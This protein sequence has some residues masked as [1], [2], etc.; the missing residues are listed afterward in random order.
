MKGDHMRYVGRNC[1]HY[2]IVL[3]G[4]AAAAVA[5]RAL[6]IDLPP[7]GVVALPGS[8]SSGGEIIRDVHIAF[9]IRDAVGTTLFAGIVQDRV[10]RR[11][12]G[13]LIFAKRIRDTLVDTPGEVVAASVTD[14][15]GL[16]T[17][18][19]YDTSSVGFRVPDQATRTGDGVLI[20]YSFALNP[21]HETE[22]S[23]FFYAETDAEEFAVVGS[24]TI[25]VAT[26]EST[27]ITV[28]TP[29]VDV[30]PPDAEIQ[31]PLPFACVCGLVKI[32]GIA[33][34][35]DGTYESDRAEYRPALG[36]AWTLIGEA[37]SAVPPPGGNLYSWDTNGLAQGYYFIR[38][39][40]NNTV[41]LSTAVV[42]IVWVD[43]QFDNLS[44]TSPSDGTVVGGTVCPAGTINDH[45]PE[46]FMVEYAPGGGGGFLPIDPGN[47]VYDGQRINQTF[48][49]WDTTAGIA[50]GDYTLR[51]TA[52]DDCGH[53]AVQSHDITVDNTAPTVE[54]TDPINCDSIGD[55][56]EI[57]GTV[58]DV[59]L[60][61]WT[62]QYTGGNA[63]NWV[64]I[65]SGNANV[66]NRLLGVWDTTGLLPCCYTI[67]IVA[68]DTAVL[69]CNGA[70]HHRSE[71]T[72]SVDLSNS[73]PSDLDG[74]GLTGINDFLKLLA[75][76]GPCP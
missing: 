55:L 70:I 63:N 32:I 52:F 62:L 44:Y 40:V 17:D 24:M 30:T 56:V 20:T 4:L 51:V 23:K 3:S 66:D 18:V 7:G 34:D 69:N 11:V 59:N 1:F 67:R 57:T 25:S 73:C 21:I 74:D 68:S 65:D 5:P 58:N 76:W 31:S 36:G 9:E 10:V 75:N 42:T 2:L 43:K 47:P 54:I 49:T 8:L 29:A 71:Y 12:D 64:T 50:D 19:D 14:Y 60:S 28:A 37:F 6:A 16:T 41:G 22:E 46:H 61:G 15:A 53:E 38:L 27:T 13:K 72:V 35:R 26:G 33:D 45:C 48:A 39:T